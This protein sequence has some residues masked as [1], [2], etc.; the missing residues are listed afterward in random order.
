MGCKRA[1]DIASDDLVIDQ[2]HP[3]SRRGLSIGNAVVTSLLWA[4]RELE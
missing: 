3:P 4:C 2:S 1:L